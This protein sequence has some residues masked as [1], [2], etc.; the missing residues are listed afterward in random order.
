MTGLNAFCRL[1]AKAANDEDCKTR[2]TVLPAAMLAA[3]AKRPWRNGSSDSETMTLTPTDCKQYLTDCV[4][5]IESMKSRCSLTLQTNASISSSN[6]RG[7]IGRAVF[8]VSRGLHAGLAFSHTFAQVGIQLIAAFANNLDKAMKLL[9]P[10]LQCAHV[11]LV[12][13][14][15]RFDCLLE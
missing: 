1:P 14:M 10:P 3:I 12:S 15:G 11:G 2:T 4:C 5:F 13:N 8:V 9:L 6:C 7:V